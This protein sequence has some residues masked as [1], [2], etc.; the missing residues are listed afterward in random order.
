MATVTLAESAKL[1]QDQLVSGLIESIVEVNPL[2]EM[3]PFTEIEG[4][5][6]AYN[7]ENALGDTQFLAVGGTIT[8]KNPAT[9][10]KVTS[11]L[12]TLIGDAEVNGLLQATRSDYTDQT[13]T[14]VASKAKSLGRQYQ[15]AMIT[16]DGTG[17]S[18][19][20]MLSLVAAGQTLEAGT[21]NG[22]QLT[23]ELIDELMDLVKDKDGQV[24]FLMST[25]A[26]R[27][28]YF[29]LLRALGGAGINETVTLPSGRQV[30]MYRGVP[31]FV[32]DFIPS[33]LTTGTAVGTTTVM[34]AGN[35]DDGSNKYGIAGLTARGAAGLRIQNVG[36]KETADET[37]T[38]VKMYCGFAN[39]SQLGLAALKGL[40][41]PA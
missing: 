22:G 34:F 40:L 8:A 25:F 7:R 16:G 39:F 18:F 36:P 2:Y 9:F 21:G 38:R 33:N 31:W 29:A 41:P 26:Q 28:K 14:Q 11:E 32:N 6:I 12:T 10:T 20:G 15:G 23:F 37:I 35:F 27:R 4:N 5:A 13:A 24:D 19:T 30:P 3:M 1:T 17:D